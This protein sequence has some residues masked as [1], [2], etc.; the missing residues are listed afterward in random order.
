MDNLAT[1]PGDAPGGGR[2][3][4]ENS[5]A[6]WKLMGR[7]LRTSTS[8]LANWPN[9][10]LLEIR[11]ARKSPPFEFDARDY[12]QRRSNCPEP[13]PEKTNLFFQSSLEVN[14]WQVA[15]VSADT[16]H[17]RRWKTLDSPL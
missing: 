10:L 5:R 11:I 13:L 1:A 12:P 17:G 14:A 7:S 9:C 4:L 2:E 15:H 8:H 6:T 16:F 3:F